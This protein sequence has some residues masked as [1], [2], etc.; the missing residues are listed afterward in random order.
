MH[1]KIITILAVIILALSLTLLGLSMRS[2][3][4]GFAAGA[5][6]RDDNT[7]PEFVSEYSNME[8][9]G[10]AHVNTY[11]GFGQNN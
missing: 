9:T 11:V 8:G 2:K 3:K 4:E 1:P 7:N 5:Y 6:Y 10:G